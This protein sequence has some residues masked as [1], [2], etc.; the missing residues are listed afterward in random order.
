MYKPEGWT[1]RGTSANSLIRRSALATGKV[2]PS[3][4][5]DE[6]M[7]TTRLAVIGAGLIGREHCA[8]ACTHPRVVLAGI[9]DTALEAEHYAGQLGVPFFSDFET[10]L[11]E[12]RP[13]GVIIALPNALHEKAG[14]CC[15]E[16]GIPSLIEKPIADT[17]SSAKSL[18]EK[19]EA[20]DVPI[21]VGHHRRHSPDIRE[22]RRIVR[23]GELGD[24]VAVN[25]MWMADKPEAYFD[26]EWRRRR[27]GGPV[28]IN[29]I[30]DI[31]CLRH[32]VGEIESV[33]AIASNRTRGFDVE[34][35]V[36]VA[37]RFE[38]GALGSFLISD[39]V[40]SPFTWEHTSGQALYFPH[41]PGDCY[42]FGGREASLAVPS[43]TVW[44]HD[45]T[46]KN[47]QDPFVHQ[48]VNLDGSGAYQNQ[49]D[50]FLAVISGDATPV[51]SA[52]DAML[53]LAATLAIDVAAREDRIVTIREMIA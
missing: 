28:L 24:L 18:V 8:L 45:G 1:N 7:T 38:N 2:A 36:S 27:G 35:T 4:N 22:A 34:D 43:M 52:R 9:A 29:L 32:I 13:D 25:G 37:L 19:S 41:Q 44:R 50:H 20:T 46:D 31:D 51:V 21:L 10:L 48:R 14:L 49:I 5:R 15:L 3:S 16:R 33:R 39:A 17:I 42:Y 47:W 12:I 40:A 23:S 6:A 53:S 26:A 30:H 11:D